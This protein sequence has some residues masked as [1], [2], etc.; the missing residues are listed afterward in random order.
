MGAAKMFNPF[1]A[2][3]AKVYGIA[4]V[5][6]LTFGLIQTARIE[7]FLFWDGL[8][9]QLGDARDTIAGM[10][11]ASENARTQQIALNNAVQGKQTEIARMTDENETN[12]L[13]LAAAADAYARRMRWADRC[14][15]QAG[16][17]AQG[18][19]AQGSDRPDPDA[20]VLSRSDFDILNAN[21]ARL[22]DVKA[23]G[24]KLIKEGLADVYQDR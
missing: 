9:E 8:Y 19:T 21:T 6:F 24:D 2:I 7:G 10:K 20:V 14:P 22:M 13:K 11:V 15:A 3:A 4:A 16:A 23:W 17:T 18:N 5:L 12:R 1:S